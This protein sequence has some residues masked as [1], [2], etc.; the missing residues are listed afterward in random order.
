MFPAP[1]AGVDG[2]LAHG[3]PRVAS[4]RACGP[5][6]A[7]MVTSS[8]WTACVLRTRGRAGLSVCQPGSLKSA[9]CTAPAAALRHW[10]Y[11]HHG[12]LL[13]FCSFFA[14]PEKCD[15]NQR[16]Y[17]LT[18]LTANA[19][20]SGPGGARWTG[21]AADGPAGKRGP[22]P[23]GVCSAGGRSVAPSPAGLTVLWPVPTARPRPCVSCPL[24]LRT[25]VPPLQATLPP[26]SIV[27]RDP[28]SKYSH[29]LRAW[30]QTGTGQAT[31]TPPSL[32]IM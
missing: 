32:A 20:C 5:G 22:A 24:T 31:W 21:Q 7:F 29:S 12:L 8:R 19:R 4:R 3:R 25:L 18:L 28:I 10:R 26:L 17:F 9:G 14:P 15:S 1:L 23:R 2:A 13:D 30:A 16:S 6:R 27:C 11:E